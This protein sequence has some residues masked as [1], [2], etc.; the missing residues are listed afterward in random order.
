MD[1]NGL[2]EE[3][4]K[5]I[6]DGRRVPWTKRILINEE[7][8]FSLLEQLRRTLP[9]E[10]RQAKFLAQERERILNEARQEAEGI[11][12]EAKSYV[13]KLADETTIAQEARSR[14]SEVLEQAQKTAREIRAGAREYADSV[15]ARLE[16]ELKSLSDTVR[17]NR[18]ELR[19]GK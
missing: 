10:L 12:R 1:V 16:G 18:E 19:T 11:V 4:E 8:V 14:A 15:L 17:R 6:D 3:L 5:R 13:E 2:L 7:E 9:E